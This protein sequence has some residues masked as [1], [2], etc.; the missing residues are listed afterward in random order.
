MRTPT[1]LCS[2]A[3][4]RFIREVTNASKKEVMYAI[5][6]TRLPVEDIIASLQKSVLKQLP[7]AG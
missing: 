2:E 5:N 1:I 6:I 3:Q 7:F 4:M